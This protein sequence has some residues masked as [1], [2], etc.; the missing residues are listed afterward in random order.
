MWALSRASVQTDPQSFHGKQK[1]GIKKNK[2]KNVIAF[3]ASYNKVNYGPL[4]LMHN[5]SLQAMYW[6]SMASDNEATINIDDTCGDDSRVP[7]I[8][9]QTT[10]EAQVIE[11]QKYR[12]SSARE[13]WNVP[14]AGRWWMLFIFSWRKE[15]IEVENYYNYWFSFISLPTTGY[16]ARFRITRRHWPTLFVSDKESEYCFHSLNFQIKSVLPTRYRYRLSPHPVF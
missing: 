5:N 15:R 16:F 10:P 3:P 2:T 7:Q 1:R 8:L 13:A 11:L 14:Q 9:E 6:V 12:I 4:K